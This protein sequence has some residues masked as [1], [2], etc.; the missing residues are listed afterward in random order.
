MQAW[1]R[2]RSSLAVRACDSAAQKHRLDSHW[3]ANLG[4][5]PRAFA[6][7]CSVTRRMSGSKPPA[8]TACA[9]GA[10]NCRLAPQVRNGAQ[11]R[12]RHARCAGGASAGA[13]AAGAS[14][15]RDDHIA[16]L[17]AQ[18]W[19]D[20]EWLVP[21]RATAARRHAARWRRAHAR[22]A[23]ALPTTTGG[24]GC[25]ECARARSRACSRSSRGR[26]VQG[27]SSQPSSRSTCARARRGGHHCAAPE[28]RAEC[29]APALSRRRAAASTYRRSRMRAPALPLALA[30]HVEVLALERERAGRCV[31]QQQQAEA[32][33]TW[34]RAPGH[35]RSLR[36]QATRRKPRARAS[37]PT[38]S[39]APQ[40]RHEG[41]PHH[42]PLIQSKCQMA[43]WREPPFSA[44]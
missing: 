11:L 7:R 32:L 23:P 17:R 35:P 22:R 25:C 36:V 28:A 43:Q 34:P 38:S 27:L 33:N 10:V 5:T 39:S 8:A 21:A 14:A 2:T 30:R 1:A 18:G 16:V 4:F 24:L 13:G 42:A 20:Q 31:A 44:P 3:H 19:R 40:H 6:S 37:P 12:R 29:D 15:A 26:R 9:L 41:Y